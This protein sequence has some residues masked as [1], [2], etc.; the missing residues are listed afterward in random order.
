VREEWF[1]SV[2]EGD[3]EEV[4]D[5]LFPEVTLG[6]CPAPRPYADWRVANAGRSSSVTRGWM[7]GKTP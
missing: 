6:A 4:L 3:F 5:L 1:D 2:D 7:R